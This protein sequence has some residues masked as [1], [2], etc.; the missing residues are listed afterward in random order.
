MGD[1]RARL[2]GFALAL[3]V[4]LLA[5]SPAGADDVAFDAGLQWGLERIG[6]PGV[7]DEATGTGVVVAVVDSGV[8]LD[9]E[10]LQ[11]QLVP[12]VSCRATA[13]DPQACTG[14]PQDDDGH[15]SHVAGIIAASTGND[16]GI[17]AIA[18]DA[19]IMP[20]KVLFRPCPGCDSSGNPDDVVAAIRWATANG[21]DVINLSLGSTNSTLF[22]PGFVEALGAAWAEGSIPVLA[23]GNELVRTVDLGSAPAVVVAASGRD[24]E[25][26]DYSQGVG[27]AQWGLAAPGGSGVDSQESCA[28]G[29]DPVGILSTYWAPDA[30]RSA[31]A[32]LSGTSMAA[33]HVSGALAL[34]LSAGA[35]PEQAVQALTA[36]AVDLG[37]P[38]ADATFGAGRIDVGAAMEHLGRTGSGDVTAP[39]APTETEPVTANS[40][41]S[42]GPVGQPQRFV[43]TP[44]PRAE[45]SAPLRAIAVTLVGLVW[46]ALAAL[47]RGAGF[48]RHGTDRSHLLR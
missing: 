30:P 15:G 1:R 43:D 4:T 35:T 19:R 13:G 34:L 47:T 26:P 24:D 17:A 14:D 18:P 6:A 10:D 25:R 39:T 20:I 33:P 9:H 31:Y 22:G 21:A 40:G 11:G 37:P 16:L 3:V 27:D 2:S 44:G 48:G 36:T 5:L 8:A 28:T 7:W 12:G 32:C 23:A 45:P 38:G 46:V 41:P 42:S 29:G